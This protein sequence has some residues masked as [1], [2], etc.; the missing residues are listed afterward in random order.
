VKD[1][2]ADKTPHAIPTD[3]NG[4]RFRSRLEGRWAIFLTSMGIA[5]EYEPEGF[6]LPSGRYLPDL[7]LPVVGMY[8]EVKPQEL[9]PA[10]KR[11]CVELV[12]ATGKACLYLVGTP[13][14][15]SYFATSLEKLWNSEKTYDL[16]LAELPYSLD[17]G[18]DKWYV[19]EHRFCCCPGT[20]DHHPEQYSPE[21]QMAV[22][23]ARGA[24]FGVYEDEAD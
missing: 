22:E 12:R 24:R 18:Y 6:D 13:D 11:L 3:W 19:Q 8:A 2:P 7:Y 10:E 5:F 15:R 9:T 23:D 17:I 16:E 1:E 14:F 4:Y 21:Y 20:Q